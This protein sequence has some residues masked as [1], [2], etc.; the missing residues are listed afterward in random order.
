MNKFHN[1]KTDSKP[2]KKK[3]YRPPILKKFGSIGDLT[4]GGISGG[5]EGV[6][7]TPKEKA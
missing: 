3:P 6:A 4:A 5:K 7:K 1:I 2:G